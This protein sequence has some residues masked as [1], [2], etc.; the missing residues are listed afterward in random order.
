MKW[1]LITNITLLLSFA[2]LAIFIILA[3]VQLFSRKTLRKVDRPLLLMPIPLVL[4]AVTYF[5]FDKLIIL[6]TRPNGSGEPSF[7]STHTMVVATIFSLVAI[8]LPNYIKSKALLVVLYILM[9]ALIII[10]SIGRVLANMHW[11]SDVIAALV[12]AAIF[13][14]IYFFL[15]KKSPKAPTSK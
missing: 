12:F 15:L 8:I 14:T 5:I 9:L 2:T 11:T 1:E 4:M 3:L 7:P 10:T 6:N 13:A